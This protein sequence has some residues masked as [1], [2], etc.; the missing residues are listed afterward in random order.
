MSFLEYWHTYWI[1]FYIHASSRKCD[2]GSF[3]NRF[4]QVIILI[5]LLW[6]VR[7]FVFFKG[8]KQFRLQ[9]KVSQGRTF[10]SKPAVNDN[11]V[12]LFFEQMS[13]QK[14]LHKK[15]DRLVVVSVLLSNFIHEIYRWH[16]SKDLKLVF[17]Y[18]I[19]QIIHK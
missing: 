6:F 4:P 1:A 7:L 18:H 2:F 12:S 11:Q 19:N 3:Y 10:L 17:R 14:G 15:A 5:N 13:G 9:E 16:E 8:A